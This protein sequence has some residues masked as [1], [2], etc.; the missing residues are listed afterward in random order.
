MSASE[1]GGPSTQ[2]GILYQNSVASLYLGRLCD[3]T[4]RPDSQRVTQ[5]RVE[6]PDHVD[7]IVITFAD[8][9]KEYVQAKESVTSS[10]N[11]WSFVW[12]DFEKQFHS[13]NFQH[14]IDRLLLQ[15]GNWRNEH[16]ELRELCARANSKS[17][18]EWQARLTLEQQALLDKI[19]PNLS[20]ESLA[21]ENL[22]SF[23]AHIDVEIW[24]LKHVEQDLLPYW[25]PQANKSP[26]ELFRLL[27]DR[28]G[29]EA[30]RRG[31]FTAYQLRKS[32]K[33]EIPD[34]DFETPIGIEVLRIAVKQCGALLRQYKHTIANTGRHIKRD[35]V[36]NIV[37]WLLQEGGS[38]EKNVSMLLDQAGM[39]KTVVM[40]D[41]LY[42]LETKNVDVLA[43]KADQQVSDLLSLQ[44]IQAQLGLPY[45]IEHT[46]ERLAKLGRTVVLVDQID[47]LSLSLAH[48]QRTLNIVLDLIARLRR[49]PNVRI[50]ISCR[51]FDRNSDPRL[52]RI[53]VDQQ[54]ALRELSEGDVQSVLN[55]LH[56][57]FHSLSEATRLLL[58]IPLHL[59][60]FA[61]AVEENAETADQAHGIASLQ[62][63]YDLIWQ[64]IVLKREAGSPSTGYRIEV[65]NSLAEYMEREQ[66]I[67]APQSLTFATQDMEQAANWLASAGIL[68]SG[69]TDW[70]FLHQ[71][72][73]DYCYA[74]HFV[75]QG[76]DIVDIVLKSSQGIFERP[77]LIQVLGFLR[78]TRPRR[79]IRDLQR[80]LNAL[81][82]RFHLHDLLLR[83]FGSLPNPSDDESTFAQRMLLSNEE[84]PALLIA[85]HGNTGWFMRLHPVLEE[86]LARGHEIIDTQVVP[87]LISLVDT[88]AQAEVM[89]LL[90]PH[91]GSDEQWN[92][93]IAYI[94]FFIRNWHTSEAI[95]LFERTV[96]SLP[97]LSH[98]DML[99][100]EAVARAHPPTGCRLIRFVLDR[101]LDEIVKAREQE[102]K[103]LD[104]S[105]FYSLYSNSLSSKL[106][107]LEG[108]IENTFVILSESEPKLFVNIMLPWLE[109][110]LRLRQ[111]P[112]EDRESFIPDELSYRWYEDNPSVL[113]A[114]IHSFISASTEL[115]RSDPATFRQIAARLANMPYE[116]AQLLLT[117]VYRAIPEMY[118]EDA[119]EFLLAD[120]RRL[121]LG[122]HE[123][124]DTRQ[125]IR[126]I[127]PHLNYEQRTKLETFILSYAPIYKT[128]GIIA[129]RM[130]GIEQFRL[131]QSIPTEYLTTR[132]VSQLRQL[133][134]KFPDIRVSQRPITTG[135]FGVVGSPI[136][137]DAARKMTDKQWLRAMQK[138][139]DDIEHRDMLKGG[140]PQLSSVLLGLV[141]ENPTRFHKLFQKVP[142]DVDDSYVSAFVNGLAESDAPVEWFF[143]AVRRF[144][145]QGRLHFKRTIV[146]AMGKRREDI[147]GDIVQLLSSWV[148]QPEGEDE[149]WWAS[150]ENRR[151]AYDSY[152]NSDRGSAFRRLMRVYDSSDTDE[153]RECKW[154]LIESVASDPSTALRIG[155]IH[156]L[157]YMIRHDRERAIVL[158]QQLLDG[159]EVLLESQY[160][161]EFL[162]WAFYKN[163]LR[164]QPYFIAMM[165][166]HSEQVQEQG[167]QLACIAALSERAM[168]STEAK[169]AAGELAGACLIS[170]PAWRRGAARVY[171]HNITGSSME[172]CKQKISLLIDDDDEQVRQ[173]IDRIFFELRREH[174]CLLR[175]FIEAYAKSKYR[176]LEYQFAEYLWNFGL[177]DPA[178]TLSIIETILPQSGRSWSGIEE[179]IRLVLRIYMDATSDDALKERAMDVFDKLMEKH[180]GQAYKI[181]SEWD[182]R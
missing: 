146:W 38:S 94:L 72:F 89:K 15:I 172:I 83:W 164:L 21:D 44:E 86:W 88:A 160:V 12:R 156:E 63:L 182:R 110:A 109:R 4:E 145:P 1:R 13:D 56:V 106:H 113:R 76:G 19:K 137:N 111:A 177:L 27:R 96:Y 18:A 181:L 81:N 178:W 151:D 161:R 62:E 173:H 14:D 23:F 71:T 58:R 16:D 154:A 11:A 42:G 95:D 82:L 143:A 139:R 39:G 105:Y 142:D 155:A 114:F 104:E 43:I 10:D 100:V 115:A 30:R 107:E 122:D 40:R 126:A 179:L 9:H 127:Y 93:R 46:V 37:A 116:T 50:L 69:K 165:N 20:P 59:D 117:H 45:S 119:F 87:Y 99:H 91:L 41:V 24:P 171:G 149:S 148:H 112:D 60:L 47:A 166:H 128:L 77:K 55:E 152:L 35:A 32:L 53:E 74:R 65:L 6:A 125:V 153:A 180:S 90:Q 73:F 78:G 68:V 57:D 17:F 97:S 54:F 167:A 98:L 141:K 144:A 147:P 169:A 2:S 136:P 129:L 67:S 36:D 49:I 92:K 158:F 163:F 80:L 130:R 162:Y 135:V 5:V 66:R 52:K 174:F 70:T 123:Q 33:D 132:G 85:M 124:Y 118:A 3:V 168:E 103:D 175:D 176:G 79:Y 48:D 61:L 133:E 8:E 159:H 84:R 75:E 131:L 108:T 140:A 29:G 150:G 64:N 134:R 138:Y 157:T 170:S 101:I 34:L 102:T 120:R 25:M 31:T 51:V 26:N 22:R 121:D 7:D 28:V